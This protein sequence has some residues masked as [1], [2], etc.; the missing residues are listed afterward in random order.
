M[1]P[2]YYTLDSTLS[3]E[4][5]QLIIKEGS[6]SASTAVLR[7]EGGSGYNSRIRRSKSS[8][9]RADDAQSDELKQALQKVVGVFFQASQECFGQAVDE[10]EPIQ[11]ASYTGPYGHY[12]WHYDVAHTG[13]HRVVSASIE[14][15]DPACYFGGGL[16]IKQV[17]AGEKPQQG[18]MTI[19]P[20]ILL[21]RAK[22]VW[23]GTRHALVL[24]GVVQEPANAWH[25]V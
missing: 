24:W 12:S 22:P 11:Y 13:P 23:W 16:E 8:F 19:F 18:A 3:S 25:G 9:F 7:D 20:S 14:L 17:T 2:V 5:C 21:H 4:D 1:R 6:K 10:I 15:S